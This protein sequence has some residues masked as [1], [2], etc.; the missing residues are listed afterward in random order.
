MKAVLFLICFLL[1]FSTFASSELPTVPFVNLKKYAGTWYEVASI[2]Q[3]FQ[4]D[5]VKNTTAVYELL[6]NGLVRVNNSCETA[7]GNIKS[8]EGRAR[9]KDA[10]TNSKL[11]VTFVKLVKWIFQFGGNYWILDLDKDY[12]LAV[13]GDPTRK[14]AWILS[15]TQHIPRSLLVKAE[16]KLRSLNYDTCQIQTSIQDGGLSN[17]EP[18]CDYVH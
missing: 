14:Y 15:R 3:S 5:C 11:K 13:V 8:A 7:D 6:S 4:R 16:R 2:P 17:R 18:L 1:G 9:V 12:S 10:S